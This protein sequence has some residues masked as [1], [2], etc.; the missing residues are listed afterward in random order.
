MPGEKQKTY[1]RFLGMI[2]SG[3]VRAMLETERQRVTD[4]KDP[5]KWENA[6]NSCFLTKPERRFSAKSTFIHKGETP[7]SPDSI[8]L[9]I[10]GLEVRTEM[11]GTTRC[12]G[13]SPPK[14]PANAA[15]T[16]PTYW[17]IF[18]GNSCGT[19]IF[20]GI[21]EK[22]EVSQELR[23][24][25]TLPRRGPQARAEFGGDWL[26][27]CQPGR[28]GTMNHKGAARFAGWA[29]FQKTSIA[30]AAFTHRA[31]ACKTLLSHPILVTTGDAGREAFYV[32]SF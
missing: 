23:R 19:Q 2:F 1:R 11:G 28:P 8:W 17:I 21:P 3:G 22:S 6:K 27:R 12:A 30:P 29:R 7:S 26:A 18:R 24:S 16:I 4:E 13:V 32:V 5:K 20:P 14:G 31:K 15:F 9:E 10:L 25:S